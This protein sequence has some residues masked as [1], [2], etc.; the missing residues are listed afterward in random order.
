V[1]IAIIS[2]AISQI[3]KKEGGSLP[4]N[5]RSIISYIIKF[6]IFYIPIYKKILIVIS[7]SRIAEVSDMF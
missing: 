1:F 5:G 6:L 3:I 4:I 2:K 7:V